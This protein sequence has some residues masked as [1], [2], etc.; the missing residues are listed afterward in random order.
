M[1]SRLERRKD[2]VKEEISIFKVLVDFGYEVQDNDYEQQFCCDLHGDGLDVKPSAR[3]Y[4]DNSWY[5]FACNEQRDSIATVQ[6]KEDLK[7]GDAIHYLEHRYN[8]P[9][10][11]WEDSDEV[12]QKPKTLQEELEA[13]YTSS[14]A[15]DYPREERRVFTLL[16]GVTQDQSLPLKTLMAL[17][18]IYDMLSWKVDKEK[19]SER[20]GVESLSKLRAK[21]VE[22]LKNSV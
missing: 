22:K 13:V 14:Q 6:A 16:D 20:A 11:P 7:F 5:C 12:Y 4:V 9:K 10:L 15:I 18:D 1:V 2:R 21:I 3:V 19:L 8:L 17:W